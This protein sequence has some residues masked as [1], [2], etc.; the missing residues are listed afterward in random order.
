MRKLRKQLKNPSAGGIAV[1]IIVTAAAGVGGYYLFTREEPK[2]KK[3]LP[4]KTTDTNDV[5][6]DEADEEYGLRFNAGCSDFTIVDPPKDIDHSQ[7]WQTKIL[8]DVVAE[9][10]A[11]GD[12]DPFVMATEALNAMGG[13]CKFPPKPNAPKRII[14]L[15]LYFVNLTAVLG[16]L[17]GGKLAGANSMEEIDDVISELTETHGYAPFDPKV[18]PDLIKEKEPKHSPPKLGDE[19]IAIETITPNFISA[20]GSPSQVYAVG[21]IGADTQVMLFD[22][23]AMKEIDDLEI[24]N[25]GDGTLLLTVQSKVP[26]NYRAFIRQSDKDPWTP[27]DSYLEVRGFIPSLDIGSGSGNKAGFIPTGN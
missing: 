25:Y 9:G 3:K 15:Y 19:A 11:D 13:D 5:V 16:V 8:S 10:V 1:A 23:K 20:N 24:D 22:E 7:F 2:K 17:G 4:E 27:T 21:N 26:G 6:E 12:L 14:N 18:I